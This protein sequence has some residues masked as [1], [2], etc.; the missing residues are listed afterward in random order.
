MSRDLT[1][2][3]EDILK[4]VD[5]IERYT[6]GL[7]QQEMVEDERTFDAV[8]LNLQIIGEAVKHIP[9]PYRKSI[10]KSNGVKLLG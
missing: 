2:Y 3:L 9:E 6:N 8:A 5:K 4:S 7:S 10:L 1:L